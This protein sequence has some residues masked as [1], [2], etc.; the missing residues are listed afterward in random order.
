MVAKRS[1]SRGG[2]ARKSPSFG[3][4][5]PAR[6]RLVT[7]RMLAKGLIGGGRYKVV[8]GPDVGLRERAYPERRGEAQILG[9]DGRDKL[10]DLARQQQRNSPTFAALM[11]QFDL[12]G[13][14]IVGGKATFGLQD[15][16][17]A[18]AL[19]E[20]FAEWTR[21]CD[22][23]DGGQYLS[24]VLK[25]I[26]RT[27]LV[28][29]EHVL[30]FD[31]GLVEDSGRLMVFE[32]DEIGNIGDDEFAARFPNGWS[33]IAGHIKNPN[34]RTVGVIC[35]RSQRGEKIF[36]A[37]SSYVLWNDPR[38]N[39][40]D[41]FWIN[42]RNMW[43]K[44]QVMGTPPCAPSLATT[45]DLEDLA[46]Y[47]LQAAK[48]N[49][50]TIAQV[51]QSTS[52]E[53]APPAAFDVGEDLSN[54]TDEEIRAAVQAEA[55]AAQTVTLQQMR[56]AAVV[57]EVMPDNC[58]LELLDTKHPN[59]NMPEFIRWQAGR[60]AAPYGLTS[61]FATLKV[62]SSYSGYMG[63][64]QMSWPA[65]EEVQ[66][67]LERQCDWI[68]CRWAKWAGRHGILDFK[69]PDGW[70]RH[71]SWAWP[72]LR[73][74][75]AVDEQNAQQMRLR[76]L[77]GSYADVYGADWREKLVHIG[78]EIKFCQAHGIPHPAMQTVSGAIVDMPGEGGK[79][80]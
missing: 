38:T 34:G 61:V 72:R 5:S 63:E 44:D 13:V 24:D 46:T 7:A 75:N 66:K 57:Y 78:E 12:N 53:P 26:L 35:S 29:G 3:S 18:D 37:D 39:Q 69:L 31:D 58:R 50:Q 28:G 25:R 73:A 1:K 79:D 17:M 19:R 70:L 36:A 68:V 16:G 47:E 30:I 49:S 2:S 60:A 59:P 76:N 33:Q 32:P 20:R 9:V 55:E 64:M 77:T 6:Q 48:K 21:D 41:S 11:K 40:M 15:E 8:S 65:F 10:V 71:V 4:L 43:R 23:Y 27:Y 80:E 67:F 74:V 42:P 14:G 52:D 45:I 54:M 22:F 56:N 51:I 62:D